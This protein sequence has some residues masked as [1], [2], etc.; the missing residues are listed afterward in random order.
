MDYDYLEINRKSWNNRVDAPLKSDFY[1]YGWRKRFVTRMWNHSLSE[2]IN[3]LIKNGFTI[4][5]FDEFDYSPY[6]C[7][8]QTTECEP[9]K[10]RIKLL[11]NNI[12]M[13][14]SIIATK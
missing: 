3:S 1:D 10:Y 8:S 4:S 11:S 14:Y 7:F 5:S 6:N 9:N 2:V 12:P 13:V